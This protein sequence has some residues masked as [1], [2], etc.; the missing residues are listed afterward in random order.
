MVMAHHT[1]L[2]SVSTIAWPLSRLVQLESYQSATSFA[3]LSVPSTSTSTILF[4]LSLRVFTSLHNITR[5]QGCCEG[6][7][8]SVSSDDI[9]NALCIIAGRFPAF[10]F[11]EIWREAKSAS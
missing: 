7:T 3:Y 9:E 4:R 8:R 6:Y 1:P 11:K 5:K 2:L 10:K